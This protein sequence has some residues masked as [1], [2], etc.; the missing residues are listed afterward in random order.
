[1]RYIRCARHKGE[2]NM[3]VFQYANNIYYRAVRDIPIGTELLVWYNNNYTQFLGI[4]LGLRNVPGSKKGQE[5]FSSAEQTP[6]LPPPPTPPPTTPPTTPVTHA[7]IKPVKEENKENTNHLAAAYNNVPEV[8]YSSKQM[9]TNTTYCY[10]G[11]N[12]SELQAPAMFSHE[13]PTKNLAMVQ[14]T[15]TIGTCLFLQLP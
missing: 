5:N 13:A 8:V 11:T 3:V 4:P 12:P 1:M 6:K 14:P 9:Q 7:D 2:Q 10:S 15:I